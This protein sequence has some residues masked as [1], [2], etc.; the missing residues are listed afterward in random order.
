MQREKGTQGKPQRM[1]SGSQR[2]RTKLNIQCHNKTQ[3]Q[4]GMIRRVAFAF[5][6]LNIIANLRRTVSVEWWAGAV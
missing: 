3:P 4:W 6:N 2:A 5:E 1:H